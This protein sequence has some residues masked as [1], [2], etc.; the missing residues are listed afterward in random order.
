MR[1]NYATN[2]RAIFAQNPHWVSIFA[3]NFNVAYCRYDFL[4]HVLTK[5]CGKWICFSLR[6]MILVVL[7][8]D[9][10]F[11]R[12]FETLHRL[13][14]GD[15]NIVEQHPWIV[16][17]TQWHQTLSTLIFNSYSGRL[18]RSKRSFEN[19]SL[20]ERGTKVVC[21]RAAEKKKEKKKTLPVN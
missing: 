9:S 20:V 4:L 19:A 12:A 6:G 16:D 14:L 7:Y 5:V 17:I 1:N 10:Y 13:M 3:F 11:S 8:T 21:Y 18:L 2:L 15:L